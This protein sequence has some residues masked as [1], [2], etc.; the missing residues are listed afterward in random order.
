MTTYPNISRRAPARI[1]LAVSLVALGLPSGDTALAQGC[2]AVRGSGMCMIHPGDSAT[3]DNANL[4]QGDWLAS[5]SYRYIHSFRH[6]I[7]DVEQTKRAV[8]GSEVINHSN[9]IDFGAQYAFTPRLSAGFALPFVTSS[10]SSLAPTNYNSVRY[11]THAT[12]IGDVRLTGYSWIWDPAKQPKGNIQIGLGLKLP[13]GD[14][15]VTDTFLTKS[16][17]VNRPVDQSIQPGDGG[18][19][20][21]LELNAYREIAPRTELF[22]QASYLFNPQ[23]Q[24][25]TMTWRDNAGITPGAVT[26][27]PDKAS[28]YEHYMSIADQYFAHAGLAYTLVPKWGLSLSLAGRIEGVPV[29]DVLGDSNGFRR[30]GFA[31]AIEPGLQIMKG[32]FTFNVSTP[33]A[34]YRNREKS[35]ADQAASIVSKSDVHGDAAFADYVITASISMRF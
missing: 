32:R 28:F 30:P 4:G 29:E 21:S 22:L 23:D 34:L 31:V 9:F 1:A 35:L 6:Y 19:G 27:G 17:P 12:G 20:F 8:D 5:I 13:T 7:G 10:R 2:V 25:R 3:P 33:V 15:S 14:D 11:T 24:N 16:G 18:W 26:V